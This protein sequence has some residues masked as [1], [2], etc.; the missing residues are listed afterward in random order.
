M[1]PWTAV[2]AHAFATGRPLAE[3]ARAIVNRELRFE[4]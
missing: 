4:K 3:V 1:P 2:R